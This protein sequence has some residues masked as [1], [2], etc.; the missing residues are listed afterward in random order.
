MPFSAIENKIYIYIYRKKDRPSICFTHHAIFDVENSVTLTMVDGI[1]LSIFECVP[2]AAMVHALPVTTV[3]TS[4][5][6]AD[7]IFIPFIVKQR[8]LQQVKR[9]NVA[10]DKY[11][12]KKFER[13]NQRRGAGQGRKLKPSFHKKWKMFLQDTDQQGRAIFSFH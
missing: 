7:N 8:Y 2:A 1:F 11:K 9:V 6:Y 13:I 5:K 12:E 3:S 4:G 10:W